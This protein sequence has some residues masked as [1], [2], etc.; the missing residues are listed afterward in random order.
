MGQRITGIAFLMV[1]GAI[2]A[3]LVIHP[4]GTGTLV[5]GVAKLWQGGLNATL[6]QTS[7]TG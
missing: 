7:A 4:T 6:G 3:D 1:V 2:I 5:N